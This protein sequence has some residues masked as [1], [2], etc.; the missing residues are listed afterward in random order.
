MLRLGSIESGQSALEIVDV[1]LQRVVNRC[2]DDYAQKAAAAEIS[3]VNEVGQAADKVRADEE[4]LTLIISNLIDN[5]IKYTPAGGQVTIRRRSE[6]DQTKID[7]SD[8]GV[9]ISPEHHARLFERFYRVDKAR[10][11]E[12]G[13]TGLGLSIVKHLA[14]AMGGR[15]SVESAP[16]QGSTF[17]VTLPT[18]AA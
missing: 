7:V 11:Q 2:V 13:G 15:V 9:G 5:A 8:T 16:Q 10:S 3:L 4:G 17:T 14:Q 12:L 1:P 18:V 6:G